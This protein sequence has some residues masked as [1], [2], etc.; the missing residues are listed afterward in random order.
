MATLRLSLSFRMVQ[1]GAVGSVTMRYATR[2]CGPNTEQLR[3]VV[4]NDVKENVTLSGCMERGADVETGR[5]GSAPKTEG[6]VP[7]F[8]WE[9]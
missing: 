2:F 3:T 7:Q 1:E 9:G 6:A 8:C 4:L 5:E